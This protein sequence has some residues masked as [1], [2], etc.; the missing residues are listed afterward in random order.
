MDLTSNQRKCIV[1]KWK[2]NEFVN[3]D[4]VENG[5]EDLLNHIYMCS[6]EPYSF[7][8]YPFGQYLRVYVEGQESFVI[9]KDYTDS[10][11][12]LLKEKFGIRL[13]KIKV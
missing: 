6:E 3:D 13:K 4:E 10:L 8:G 12:L 2:E 1:E 5:I 7:S 9:F 11:L